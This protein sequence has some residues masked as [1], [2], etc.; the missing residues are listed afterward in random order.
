MEGGGPELYGGGDKIRK[1]STSSLGKEPTL[2]LRWDVK[3]EFVRL[4]FRCSLWE[5]LSNGSTTCAVFLDPH[6]QPHR[7]V[8]KQTQRTVTNS[9]EHNTAPPMAANRA[10]LFVSLSFF[11]GASV[12]VVEGRM[13]KFV[14]V[15]MDMW[16]ELI[17]FKY[18][19]KQSYF[20]SSQ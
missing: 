1:D 2:L 4:T 8:C 9:I 3:I 5:V 6:G 18:K 12:V 14:P 16:K 11:F 10:T 15:S 17:A 19:Q 20:Y 7:L 13:T